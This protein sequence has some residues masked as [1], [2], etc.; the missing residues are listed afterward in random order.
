MGARRKGRELAV[1]AL[2]QIDARGGSSVEMLRL[3]WEQADAGP[4]AKDF[5]AAL[6]SGVDQHRERIDQL[7]TAASEHWRF[8]RLSAVDLGVLRV[9]TYELLQHEAPTSVILDE[10]IE[11]ARRFGTNESAVF[12]NGVLDHIAAELGVKEPAG[13]RNARGD[14]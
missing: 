6:V 3:F 11:V 14:G 8:E 1:Q 5:A 13:E 12:V 2:Y 7:I 10:A 4:R 9:A